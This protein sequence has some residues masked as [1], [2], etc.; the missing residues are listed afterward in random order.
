VECELLLIGIVNAKIQWLDGELDFSWVA[1]GEQ[2]VTGLIFGA[3]E[4]SEEG[5]DVVFCA[6]R[7]FPAEKLLTEMRHG[8]IHQSIVR[9]GLSSGFK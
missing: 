2:Q 8:Q 6:K 9:P 1:S 3:S 4:V 5:F 7:N